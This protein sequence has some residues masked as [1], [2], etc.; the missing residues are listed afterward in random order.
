MT[1]RR[2]VLVVHGGAGTHAAI[3]GCPEARKAVEEGVVQAARRGYDELRKGG[4][5]LDAVEAAVMSLE[6]NA[7]FNAGHGSCLTLE[8]AVE[9]DASIMDG[10]SLDAGSVVCVSNV[11]NP[12]HLARAVMEQTK[13]VS[14]ISDR[15]SAFAEHVGI[16]TVNP[17][18]LITEKSLRRLHSQPQFQASRL[19]DFY[20]QN[21]GSTGTAK[22]DNHGT[23]GAVAL[24]SHG[25]VAYATSTGGIN[26]KMPGRMG[27]SPI[28]GSGGYADN[29][30]GCVSTTGDGEALMKTCLARQI[31]FLMEQGRSAQQAVEEGLSYLQDRVGGSGGAIVLTPQGD[32]GISFVSKGMSWAY[33]NSP[34]IHY[35]IYHGE[36]NTEAV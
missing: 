10:H 36:D 27:D 35:G 7:T 22:D 1:E 33:V 34:Q 14:L 2:P 4:S 3:A 19:D 21:P 5:S 17:S 11:A 23:V 12:V 9:M 6:D 28:I 30:C 26:A 25:N 18:T 15:A 16:G 8:G 13:H 32:I 31:T 20:K 29:R 24:D